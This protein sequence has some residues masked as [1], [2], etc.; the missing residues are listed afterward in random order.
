MSDLHR[1]PLVGHDLPPVRCKV[2]AKRA[3]TGQLYWYWTRPT[4]S[5]VVRFGP[6]LN[7]ADAHNDIERSVA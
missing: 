6:F 3:V 7:P 2:S 1:L 4:L 5:G